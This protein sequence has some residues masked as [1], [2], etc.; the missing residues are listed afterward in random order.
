MVVSVLVLVL[1]L[2]GESGVRVDLI[3]RLRVRMD[4]CCLSLDFWNL[5]KVAFLSKVGLCVTEGKT[6]TKPPP[7]LFLAEC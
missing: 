1:V 2:V 3:Q 4:V 7:F 6:Q 5:L